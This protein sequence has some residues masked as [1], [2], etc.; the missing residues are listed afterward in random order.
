MKPEQRIDELVVRLNEANEKYRLGE[1]SGMRDRDFDERLKELHDLEKRHPEFV[2]ADSP[3]RRIGVEPLTG[4]TRV[5][6]SV[7]MLSIENAYTY[8]EIEKFLDQTHAESYTLEHKVDGVALSLIYEKG[9]LVQAL[10][11]G[12]GMEGD[13]VT[14]NAKTI[15]GIPFELEH[16]VDSWFPPARFEIRGEVYMPKSAFMQWNAAVGGQYKNP[17]NATAGAIR[18]LNASE[19]AKRPLRF[20]AHSAVSQNDGFAHQNQF[21]EMCRSL[22]FATAVYPDWIGFQS[23]YNDRMLREFFQTQYGTEKEN[24]RIGDLDFETDGIVIKVN[25]FGKRN[26]IGSTSIGPKWQIAYKIEK[27]EGQTILQGVD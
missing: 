7:P 13:D 11:R 23:C 26:E 5:R 16:G 21:L 27:Y 18:L 14:H 6:H 3:T 2:R 8:P 24:R 15:P 20:L 19:C 9:R 17:R 22:G 4:L 25:D 10:T 1:Y 12:D